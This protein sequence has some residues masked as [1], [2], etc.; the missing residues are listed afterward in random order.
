MTENRVTKPQTEGSHATSSRVAAG[1]GESSHKSRGRSVDTLGTQSTE[2]AMAHQGHTAKYR[3]IVADPPWPY[4]EGFARLGT[5]H[6]KKDGSKR[7]IE[8]RGAI[9]KIELPYGSMQLAEIAVLPIPALAEDDARLFLWTTMRYL[10]DAVDMTRQWG[11]TYKQMLVWDK[12]PWFQPVG[13]SVAP[14]AAEF[15]LVATRGTPPRSGRWP[16]SVIRARKARTTHSRKPDAFCDLVE[17]VSPGP[18]LEMFARRQRLGWDTWGDE[19]LN[20]VGRFGDTLEPR[21]A[22]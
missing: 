8:E 7:T 16:T 17:A 15:L 12:T 2:G 14:N 5:N 21:C 1:H 19:A 10:P 4:P 18:Y 9:T 22:S 3:T 11:F 6:R 13:G 20:H